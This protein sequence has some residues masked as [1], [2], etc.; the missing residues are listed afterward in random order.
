MFSPSEI[1]HAAA[2]LSQIIES[3]H[4]KIVW[5][6]PCDVMYSLPRAD[7]TYRFPERGN[8]CPHRSIARL[9]WPSLRR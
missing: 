8:K 3:L 2:D 1:P 5:Y 9:D 7:S 6:C 4:R